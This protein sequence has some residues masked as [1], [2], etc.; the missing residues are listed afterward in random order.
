MKKIIN[1]SLIWSLLLPL[2]ALGI[3]AEP[4]STVA[5]LGAF[6]EEIRLLEAK[7]ANRKDTHNR[8]TAIRHRHPQ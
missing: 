5:I 3:E 8:E 1:I 2:L 6:D 7:L 4:S